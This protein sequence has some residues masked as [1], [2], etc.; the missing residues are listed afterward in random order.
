MPR[1][2]W[3]PFPSA[4][5]RPSAFPCWGPSGS[6][7][8]AMALS[9]TATSFRRHHHD[10]AEAEAEGEVAVPL[11]RLAALVR[12]FPADAEIAITA[13]DR[14]A[15]VTS[16]KARFKLPVFPIADLLERHVLG[17]KPAASSLMPRSPATC[18]PGRRLRPRP[19]RA[20]SIS[21]AFSCTTS[22]TILPR[23]PPTGSGSAVSQRRPRRRSRRIAR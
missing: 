15:T 19:R 22:A 17:E 20:G 18:L 3:L 6:P 12:H 14:A 4:S 2:A 9:V 11:E 7:L 13:D 16:G 5:G 23:S 1:S 21:T 8:V 10:R